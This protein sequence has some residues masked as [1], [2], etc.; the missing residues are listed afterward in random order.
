[1]ANRS[2]VLKLVIAGDADSLKKTV[3]KSLGQLDRLDKGA[4][5]TSKGGFRQ[6][7]KAAIGAAAGI[8]AVAI[9]SNELKTSVTQTV[10][11]A[12]STRALQRAT[13]LAAEDASALAA[14]LKVRGMDTN[15]LGRSFTTLAR[16][17]EAAKTGTGGAA[18]A[19]AKL[20]VSQRAIA[21]GN[22]NQVLL[23]IAD[24]FNK[25]G[26]GT[27]KA[28][29]AQQLF[30]RNSRD[31]L[32][33]LEGGSQKLREQLGLAPQLS[34]AQVKQSLAMVNAQRQVDLA[35]MN[36]RTTLG[37]TLM[38]V[39]ADG[40]NKLAKFVTEMKTGKGEGGEFAE[41]I[42]K[43]W[44]S[45]KPAVKQLVDF[46]K[47]VFNFAA[48]NPEVVKIAAS[49]AAVGLAIK[50]IKFVSAVSGLS[51]F[52]KAA[53]GLGGPLKKLF[54]RFGTRAGN[55]FAGEAAAGMA[56]SEGLGGALAPSGRVG[57]MG[58]KDGKFDKWGRRMGK[59]A[60]FGFIAG[61]IALFGDELSRAISKKLGEIGLPK[62][63]QD[64]FLGF[65]GADA[66]APTIDPKSKA[67]K[68]WERRQAPRR[69]GATARGS[70]MARGS[71]RGVGGMRAPSRRDPAANWLAS[72]G[73]DIEAQLALAEARSEAAQ[74]RL[75]SLQN[76]TSG[77]KKSR[78][79]AQNLRELKRLAKEAEREVTKLQRQLGRRD[80]LADITSQFKS[81][82]QGFADAYATGLERI[83]QARLT[84]AQKISQQI[85]DDQLKNLDEEE[86]QSEEARRIRELR[87]Q[88]E[89]EQKER[90]DQDYAENKQA[91]ETQLERAIRNGNLRG[92]QDLREQIEALD[93]QRRDTLR[94]REIA[95]LS[96]SLQRQRKA[97]QDE[98]EARTTAAQDYYDAQ[99]VLNQQLVE[100][101][102]ARVQEQMDALYEQLESGKL[103]YQD[104]NNRINELSGVLTGLLNADLATR[105]DNEKT[106]LEGSLGKY[107][108]FVDD[109]NKEFER[110]MD[111]LPKPEI[112]EIP[113]ITIDVFYNYINPPPQAPAPSAPPSASQPNPDPVRSHAEALAFIRRLPKGS[114]RDASELGRSWNWSKEKVWSWSKQSAVKKVLQDRDITIRN[115]ASGG[116]LNRAGLTLVGETGPELIMGG[117]TGAQVMSATRTARM[118]G[119]GV[120]LN[121]YPQTTADDPVALARA[122]GWQL[123]TR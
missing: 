98:Y 122:L 32:P 81:F 73:N 85:L 37:T 18:D 106:A 5:K 39:L 11:L 9:A 58:K 7:G 90:E 110:V 89:R 56:G 22:F 46:G 19:F 83:Q 29:V 52:L 36:V 23:G 118:S 20:G 66:Q 86:G 100:D 117:P 26:D 31:L 111:T 120:T 68:D 94:N 47:A 1:M 38:P 10:D 51:D 63:L 13:G 2:S 93:Q 88:Q 107:G 77:R 109:V 87:E 70:A 121:V 33:L 95:E 103:S 54:S 91:L 80:A 99:V 40:A 69:R 24:G 74:K 92:Q 116:L 82:A 15:K 28:S 79:E 119:A 16:Q 49:L 4:Q 62:L 55:A 25:L 14:V 115:R 76:A 113:R 123:A 112:P 108:K 102:K 84:A 17:I 65:F 97:A 78:T 27:S 44:E 12:K 53:K 75:E 114:K 50:G 72:F 35:L 60:V 45:V 30:G 43:I 6:I 96:E 105:A 104:Y 3:N 34:Q 64:H 42:R 8:G 67:Y 101:Y 21:S 59:A 61:F 41:K 48:N 71:A 57:K